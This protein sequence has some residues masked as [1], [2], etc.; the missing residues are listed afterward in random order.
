MDNEENTAKVK[1]KI[2]LMAVYGCH[3]LNYISSF[4]SKCGNYVSLLENC[5][6]SIEITPTTADSSRL[7]RNMKYNCRNDKGTICE[8]INNKVID[9]NQNSKC[10]NVFIL[11]LR[12]D[13]V[14][15]CLL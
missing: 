15:N 11:D 5:C 13:F 12:V 6:L 9:E 3:L 14:L 10:I 8:D 1:I 7:F 4:I 2:S